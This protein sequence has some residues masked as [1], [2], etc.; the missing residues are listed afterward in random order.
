MLEV[1]HY[2]IH[3]V[4]FDFLNFLQDFCVPGCS[5]PLSGVS[6][7]CYVQPFPSLYLAPELN[8]TNCHAKLAQSV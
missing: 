6:N 3:L 5:P 2:D 1:I 4:S 8:T 7:T